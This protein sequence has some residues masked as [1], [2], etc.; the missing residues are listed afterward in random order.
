[1]AL[2]RRRLFVF[3]P[4]RPDL[5]ALVAPRPR[6]TATTPH[7]FISATTALPAAPPPAA[8]P[9]GASPWRNFPHPPR[10]F[11]TRCTPPPARAPSPPSRFPLSQKPYSNVLVKRMSRLFSRAAYFPAREKELPRAESRSIARAGERNLRYGGSFLPAP[12]AFPAP[13]QS[14]AAPPPARA[15]SRLTPARPCR[16]APALRAGYVFPPPPS[17]LRK[18]VRFVC[19]CHACP[20]L[21]AIPATSVSITSPFFGAFQKNKKFIVFPLDKARPLCYTTNRNNY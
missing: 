12:L 7:P 11:C 1:M 18:A 16:T 21:P 10:S 2:R 3:P 13:Q 17:V 9:H 6:R 15:P 14:P 5:F 8:E 4:H 19:A 20:R